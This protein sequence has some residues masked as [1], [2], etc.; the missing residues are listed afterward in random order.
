MCTA[1]RASG[2]PATI[3][4]AEFN[5]EDFLSTLGALISQQ[6]RRSWAVGAMVNVWEE[7]YLSS[8]LHV[9]ANGCDA[10]G[11]CRVERSLLWEITGS[12]A[13]AG[14]DLRVGN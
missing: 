8:D 10:C 12:L 9:N 14:N 1:T 4:N 2:V 3:Y 5:F 6:G 11:C 7:D 13:A